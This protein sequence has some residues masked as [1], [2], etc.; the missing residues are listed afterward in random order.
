[1][2]STKL[3]VEVMAGDYTGWTD[4][5]PN[6][7]R[8][9]ADG[10][11]LTG[12]R[13]NHSRVANC[14]ITFNN[15]GQAFGADSAAWVS[16]ILEPRRRIRIRASGANSSNALSVQH[17]GAAGNDL[18]GFSQQL[19]NTITTGDVFVLTW[20]ARAQFDSQFNAD[21]VLIETSAQANNATAFSYTN[22]WQSYSATFTATLGATWVKARFDNQMPAG[23]ASSIRTIEYKNIVLKKN[24]GAN[25]LTNGDFA[26]GFASWSTYQSASPASSIT[27]TVNTDTCCIFNGLIE[28]VSPAP[29][30]KAGK[31]TT[32][33]LCVDFTEVLRLQNIGLALQKDQRGDQIIAT[34]LPLANA[35]SYY[36]NVLADNPAAYYRLDEPSGV[37]AND[38]SPNGRTGS[39]NGGVVYAQPGAL[40]GDGDY[41]VTF[42]GVNAY[43][44]L[45]VPAV[46]GTSFSLEAWVNF[47]TVPTTGNSAEVFSIGD[48]T[49][50]ANHTLVFGVVNNT[51]AV[52]MRCQNYNGTGRSSSL[53]N[54][55][56]GVW[57]H[58]VAVF[59][60]ASGIMTLYNNGSVVGIGAYSPLLGTPS[61]AVIGKDSFS[62]G[63]WINATIDEVSI[64][65]TALSTAAVARHYTAGLGAYNVSRIPGALQDSGRQIFSRAFD[66]YI[67][68]QVSILDAATDASISEYGMQWFDRD[69]T[70]RWA[71][72]DFEPRQV[73]AAPKLTLSD[74]MPF[75]MA[76]TRA[77]GTVT[78]LV[79]LVYHPRQTVTSTIVLGRVTSPVSIP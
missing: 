18:S 32:D 77:A 46:G 53:T 26:N 54:V 71:A 65:T 58:W 29:F 39:Y 3:I 6:V 7:M 78:N 28:S 51:G 48:G 67:K 20:Q 76:L 22:K 72:R 37:I 38:S 10:L 5:T 13:G 1:M 59:D 50:T 47:I 44:N 17:S 66:R 60:A 25:L 49:S 68:S 62:N 55:T 16:A 23:A 21:R 75:D 45:P 56:A 79:N 15:Q 27:A 69:G 30:I 52:T 9:R 35:A 33:V 31:L 36:N 34:L 14:R 73:A 61:V 19:N 2:S 24:G 63:S 41:S 64:Y 12:P 4:V 42:N 43:G 70:F 11:G 57:Y 40:V 74:G 8:I